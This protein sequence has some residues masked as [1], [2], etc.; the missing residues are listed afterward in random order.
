MNIDPD[1]A[2]WNEYWSDPDQGFIFYQ[3]L[4]NKFFIFVLF[5][6]LFNLKQD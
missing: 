2:F 5:W 4:Y 6:F 3:N 1:P